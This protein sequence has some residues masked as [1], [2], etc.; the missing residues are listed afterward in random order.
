LLYNAW[1]LGGPDGEDPSSY[2]PDYVNEDCIAAG[3]LYFPPE[4][5]WTGKITLGA[6]L[7][8]NTL[9]IGMTLTG[10]TQTGQYGS[11]WGTLDG[12]EDVAGEKIGLRPYT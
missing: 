3:T 1:A 5:E 2:C 11:L 12:T 6:R 7:L 9:D 8:D 10:A 4:P